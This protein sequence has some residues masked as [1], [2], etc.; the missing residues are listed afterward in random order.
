MKEQPLLN[1][2]DTGGEDT[3]GVRVVE[4]MYEITKKVDK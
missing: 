3:G 2:K 4:I 1:L